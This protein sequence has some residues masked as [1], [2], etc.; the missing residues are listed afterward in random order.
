[1]SQVRLYVGNLPYSIDE[2]GLLAIFSQFGFQ[3]SRPQIIMDRETNRPKGFGF[4]EVASQKDAEAAIA[5]VSGAKIESRIIRVS[6]ANE[7]PSRSGGGGGG[8]RPGGGGGPTFEHRKS[9]GGGGG[10]RDGGRGGRGGRR[11]SSDDDVWR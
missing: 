9:S 2:T 10:G 11:G 3:A 5:A 1:M 4:V 7:R 6:I 8:G